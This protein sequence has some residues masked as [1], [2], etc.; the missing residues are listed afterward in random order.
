[1][2]KHKQQQ[3]VI[4]SLQTRICLFNLSFGPERYDT[5]MFYYQI[6]DHKAILMGDISG[7]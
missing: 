7:I 5:R 1:M 6:L 3:M 2:M 4:Y